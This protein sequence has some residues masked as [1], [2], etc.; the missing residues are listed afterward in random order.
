MTGGKWLVHWYA[1]WPEYDPSQPTDMQTHT[2]PKQGYGKPM[3][4]TIKATLNGV[5]VDMPPPADRRGRPVFGKRVF[6]THEFV[7]DELSYRFDF[8]SKTP[9]VMARPFIVS[10]EVTLLRDSTTE[11]EG[12]GSGTTPYWKGGRIMGKAR[13]ALDGKSLAKPRSVFDGE[14]PQVDVA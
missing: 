8:T 14:D 9:E 2:F 12:T 13:S 4:D 10:G 11:D 1:A 5:T 7:G 6:F 3:V